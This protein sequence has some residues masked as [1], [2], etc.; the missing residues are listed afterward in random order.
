MSEEE[1]ENKQPATTVTISNISNQTEEFQRGYDSHEPPMTQRSFIQ[2]LDNNYDMATAS[3]FETEDVEEVE[4]AETEENCVNFSDVA[5]HDLVEAK[6]NYED[7][8]KPPTPTPPSRKTTPASGLRSKP[9]DT[10]DYVSD[11]DSRSRQT[12]R[13]NTFSQVREDETDDAVADAADA[14]NVAALLSFQQVVTQLQRSA[15]AA[16]Q[17]EN[18]R[19]LTNVNEFHGKMSTVC[20]GIPWH[21][22]AGRKYDSDGGA[23]LSR[24]SGVERYRDSRRTRS[25]DNG[26]NIVASP[27]R[28]DIKRLKRKKSRYTKSPYQSVS[29]KSSQVSRTLIELP[30]Y[31]QATW[32]GPR[33]RRRATAGKRPQ[34]RKGSDPHLWPNMNCNHNSANI[35]HSSYGL[36]EGTHH[37]YTQHTLPIDMS[38]LPKELIA[39]IEGQAD[40]LLE[41]IEQLDFARLCRPL[42]KRAA[43]REGSR[44]LVV[45]KLQLPPGHRDLEVLSGTYEDQDTGLVSTDL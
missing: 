20:R 35:S 23:E 16:R 2:T 11:L 18:S 17:Q 1:E 7:D 41:P 31:S 45:E 22:L 6:E 8:Y 5:T 15:A 27:K 10:S 30:I 26:I 33:D 29:M 3:T 38:Y 9:S 21:H 28:A 12:S 44:R 25:E 24:R 4:E 36:C 39:K 34:W 42:P 14:A 37:L 19:S 13:A 32:S 40:R 43:T